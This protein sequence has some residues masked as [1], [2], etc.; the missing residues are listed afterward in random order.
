MTEA[1]RQGFM[2]K[3]AEHGVSPSALVKYAGMP[4]FM[5]KALR[6][7]CGGYF[8]RLFGGDVKSLK[9]ITDALQTQRHALLRG[10]DSVRAAGRPEMMDMFRGQ[11]KGLSDAY[12][13]EMAKLLKERAAVATTRARTGLSLAGMTGL[14]GLYEN[15]KDDPAADRWDRYNI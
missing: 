11:L 2:E 4:R 9:K 15:A 3:C 14:Y 7:A 8:H 1:Y 12:R 13:K 5:S 10:M 6:S